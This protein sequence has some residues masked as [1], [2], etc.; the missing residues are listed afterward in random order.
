MVVSP[1][2]VPHRTGSIRNRS[3]SSDVAETHATLFPYCD[4]QI[5]THCHC[6][7]WNGMLIYSWHLIEW[8]LP[9]NFMHWVMFRCSCFHAIPFGHSAPVVGQGHLYHVLTTPLIPREHEYNANLDVCPLPHGQLHVLTNP[10]LGRT[11]WQYSRPSR[12]NESI[13][14]HH[15]FS[16]GLWS[17]R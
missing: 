13:C 1:V 8:Y 14:N 5:V 16:A 3:K 12:F 7:W 11:T 6:Q 4:Q 2:L 10:E 15:F 17:M 9:S